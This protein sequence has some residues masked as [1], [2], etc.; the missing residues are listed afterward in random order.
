MLCNG[1]RGIVNASRA[2][3]AIDTAIGIANS[4][5]PI[6]ASVGSATNGIDGFGGDSDSARN[7]VTRN[8]ASVTRS[9]NGNKR[10]AN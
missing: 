8:S 5:T 9:V 1:R 3:A 7:S 6:C 2:A 4:N 10:S